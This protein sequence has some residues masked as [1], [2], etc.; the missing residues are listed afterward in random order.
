M[1]VDS[2]HAQLVS[3]NKRKMALELR[4]EA[5]QLERLIALSAQAGVE[6]MDILIVALIPLSSSMLRQR[7]KA[8]GFDEGGLDTGDPA[9]AA[10]TAAPRAGNGN[11][12]PSHHTIMSWKREWGMTHAAGKKVK[13]IQPTTQAPS[14]TLPRVPAFEN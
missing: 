12:G 2:L 13:S 8:A 5:R 6:D 4:I 1:K 7:L 14:R 11:G 9:T 10:E 3:I